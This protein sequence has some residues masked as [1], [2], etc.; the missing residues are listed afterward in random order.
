[1]SR[2]GALVPAE[3]LRR[4]RASDSGSDA[5]LCHRS[6]VEASVAE[7]RRLRRKMARTLKPPALPSEI[8]R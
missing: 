1:M 3:Y 4:K 2:R 5:F 6:A 8:G 7:G